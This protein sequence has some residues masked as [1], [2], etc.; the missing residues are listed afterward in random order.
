MSRKFVIFVPA[1][2]I[3]LI[4]KLWSVSVSDQ[5]IIQETLAEQRRVAFR[6]DTNKAKIIIQKVFEKYFL[7]RF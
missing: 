2:Q 3:Q 4:I 6:E 7:N 5:I 1:T